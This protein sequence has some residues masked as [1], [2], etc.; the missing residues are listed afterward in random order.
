M[1]I[2]IE[3][4]QVWFSEYFNNSERLEI[5]SIK[6]CSANHNFQSCDDIR[7]FCFVDSEDFWHHQSDWHYYYA[8]H[9]IC[10]CNKIRNECYLHKFAQTK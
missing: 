1:K 3:V 9:V 4:G 5:V 6:D 10:I 2:K 8:H 7:P